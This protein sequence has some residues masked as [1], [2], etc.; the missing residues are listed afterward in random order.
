MKR[1]RQETRIQAGER[2]ARG[3]GTTCWA[4]SVAVSLPFHLFLLSFSLF[5]ATTRKNSYLSLWCTCSASCHRGSSQRRCC[6]KMLCCRIGIVQRQKGIS[7]FIRAWDS[8]G[9]RVSPF[10]LPASSSAPATALSLTDWSASCSSRGACY[11]ATQDFVISGNMH[12]RER[13]YRWSVK[14]RSTTG[15]NT[16]INCAGIDWLLYSP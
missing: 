7:V 14:L 1:G 3:D 2:K 4:L 16:D 13:E 5:L 10:F 6:D 11:R 12:A 9:K 8:V 15:S